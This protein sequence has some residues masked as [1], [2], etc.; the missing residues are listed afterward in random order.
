MK[1][2]FLIVLVF[3][4]STATSQNV[5]TF[6]NG[7][8]T[9]SYSYSQIHD[10]IFY[11][12][13]PAWNDDAKQLEY[14]LASSCKN[15][16]WRDVVGRYANWPTV[17]DTTMCCDEIYDTTYNP[18]C[19]IFLVSSMLPEIKVIML[20]YSNSKT[21]NIAI[22]TEESKLWTSKNPLKGKEWWELVSDTF[23]NERIKLILNK[24][25]PYWSSARGISVK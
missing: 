16:F 13:E 6:N 12:G 25:T 10:I 11:G 15:D 1:N 8:R 2:L 24:E 18:G 17:C 3:L 4:F 21:I 5:V 19:R 23:F 9:R 20:D 22:I 7:S 14:E